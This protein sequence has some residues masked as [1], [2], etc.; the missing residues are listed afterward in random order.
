M[1]NCTRDEGGPLV[2][3]LQGQPTN[4]SELHQSRADVVSVR[5]KA[6][7]NPSGATKETSASEPTDEVSKA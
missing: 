1:R 6:G 5:E 7:V 4:H 3:G 2:G